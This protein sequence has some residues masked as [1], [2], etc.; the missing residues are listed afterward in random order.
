MEKDRDEM[1]EK[2]KERTRKSKRGNK[3]DRHSLFI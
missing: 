3:E 1:E 2:K